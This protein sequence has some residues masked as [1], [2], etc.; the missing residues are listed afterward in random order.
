MHIEATQSSVPTRKRFCGAFIGTEQS[1]R[2]K[3]KTKNKI[4]S[5]H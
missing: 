1:S 2:S 5:R 4:K 3:T